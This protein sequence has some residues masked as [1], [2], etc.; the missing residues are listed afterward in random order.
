[1]LKHNLDKQNFT[2]NIITFLSPLRFKMLYQ[3]SYTPSTF[4]ATAL[5]LQSYFCYVGTKNSKPNDN[6]LNHM[7][8][9][10]WQHGS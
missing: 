2:Q 5:L 10:T 8:K 1:M 9:K 7:N 6:I 4:N 3:Y